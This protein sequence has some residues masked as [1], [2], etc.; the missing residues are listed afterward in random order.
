MLYH[1]GWCCLCRLALMT[2]YDRNKTAPGEQGRF[3][4]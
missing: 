4:N 1:C 3:S 2:T